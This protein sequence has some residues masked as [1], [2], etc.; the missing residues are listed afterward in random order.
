MRRARDG[1][2]CT[3][4]TAALAHHVSTGTGLAPATSAPGLGSPMPDLHRDWAR[5]GHICTGTGLTPA[6]SAPGLG[7]PR[8]H[9]HRDCAE[10][11]PARKKVVKLSGVGPWH[12][13]RWAIASSERCVGT[14]GSGGCPGSAATGSMLTES[15]SPLKVRCRGINQ[16]GCV[17]IH[18][19]R[20][21]ALS[22][23][24]IG[25]RA[26]RAERKKKG[27]GSK[28]PSRPRG[29]A[30]RGGATPGRCGRG[31]GPRPPHAG[32]GPMWPTARPVAA[33]G[34]AAGLLGTGGAA[35]CEASDAAI[36]AA[37]SAC[38]ERIGSRRCRKE[39][40]K[41]SESP[42]DGTSKQKRE[43]SE[44]GG[45]TKSPDAPDLRTR[46]GTDRRPSSRPATQRS[47]HRARSAL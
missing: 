3:S 27:N 26:A 16:P 35:A 20:R 9:L 5:P 17:S 8:P 2:A 14:I 11:L 1:R 25:V 19:K 33:G 18:M 42:S 10:S 38:S 47:P 28:T 24:S 6:T 45:P 22:S 37:S 46:D 13:R 31:A 4:D 36:A 44:H 7:S 21:S 41:A 34:A 15:A 32:P 23:G 29:G 40:T 12:V 39:A 30:G 43:P